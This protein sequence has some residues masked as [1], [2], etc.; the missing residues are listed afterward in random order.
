MKKYKLLSTLILLCLS[1]T[2]FAAPFVV[3][4][5]TTQTVTHCGILLD[6]NAKV[7]IPVTTVTPTTAICKFD[8]GNV[9][10]GSHTIRA[11]FIN[12]D[13]LWG[14]NESVQSVGF[15]FERPGASTLIS[16]SGL[17]LSK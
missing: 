3:S 6:T 12:F 11:T 9:S 5:S 8:V 2:I 13:P 1:P 17:G 16:P 4:D 10:V 14:R 15:T 7:E